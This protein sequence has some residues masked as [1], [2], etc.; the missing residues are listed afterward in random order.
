ML[1]I[2]DFFAKI[3][4]WIQYYR[5]IGSNTAAG[6]PQEKNAAWVGSSVNM[7]TNRPST[8]E[9]I[10]KQP[11]CGYFPL[12]ALPSLLFVK[13]PTTTLTLMTSRLSLIM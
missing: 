7:A 3:Q 1:G 13:M 10:Y 6:L 4:D 5:N 2:L 9:G 8:T 11:L 12:A